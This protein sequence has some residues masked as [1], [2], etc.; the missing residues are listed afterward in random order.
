[1]LGLTGWALSDSLASFHLSGS[2]MAAIGGNPAHRYG[3]DGTLVD[4]SVTAATG[5]LGDTGFGSA[6]QALQSLARLQNTS[7]RLS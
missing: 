1:M 7:L 4:V 2:D 6:V 3:H 5:V